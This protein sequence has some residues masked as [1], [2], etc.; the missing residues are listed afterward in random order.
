MENTVELVLTWA[1]PNPQAKRQTDLFTR[2]CTTHG[3]T[4]YIRSNARHF[5]PKLPV[6]WGDLDPHLIHDSFG[7]SVLIIKTVSPSVEPVFFAHMTAECLCFT[8]GHHFLL[9]IALCRGIH[10]QSNTWFPGPICVLNPN[11]ISIGS[12]VFSGP[13]SVTD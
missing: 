5:S 9:K 8:M 11:G 7:Q 3:K 1:H 10:S 12:A 6:P 13:T 2:F 4:S